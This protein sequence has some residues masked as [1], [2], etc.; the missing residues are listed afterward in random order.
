MRVAILGAG[1]SGLALGWSLKQCYGTA[2]SLSIYEKSQRPGGWIKSSYVDGFLFEE[3]P[4][5]CRSRAAGAATLALIESLGM[6]S[7]VVMASAAAKQR[8]LYHQ[9]RLCAIPGF[10]GMPFSPLMRGVLPALCKEW[11]QPPGMQDDESIYDFVSRRFTQK[12][13]ERLADPMTAGIYAGD[14]RQLSMRSCFPQLFQW[15]QQ[16]GSV[17]GGMF[18]TRKDVLPVTP[19]VEKVQR[20]SSIFSLR[21]G[22]ESLVTA[23]A[24]QLKNDLKLQTPVDSIEIKEGNIWLRTAAAGQQE[25][26]RVFCALPAS[27][28]LKLFGSLL[29]KSYIFPAASVAT[30]GMGW[31][32][33]VLDKQGFGYLVPSREKQDVLGVVFDS[34]VFPQQSG[35]KQETRLTAMLGGAQRPEIAGLAVDEIKSL[36][37]CSLRNHLGIKQEPDVWH[38]NVAKE[39]IPQ[40]LV[41]HAAAVQRLK[42]DIAKLSPYI[43][44]IGSAWH[45][46]AVNDCIAEAAKTRLFV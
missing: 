39:A 29:K 26:D 24:T 7:E 12:V 30:V 16:Y 2:I 22:M 18:R 31:K 33:T 32:A 45:G 1:I 36:V 20:E 37:M 11:R 42:Q 6:A 23:L 40:Y 10:L 4:R 27:E 43:S 46:V 34:A 19:F 3:G 8:Y 17:T 38:L 41:G 9:G 28:T 25:F 5:S 21:H 44:L 15:E 14:I 13:A 35:Y